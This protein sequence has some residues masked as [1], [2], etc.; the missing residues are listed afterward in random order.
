TTTTADLVVD[1]SGLVGS[2]VDLAVYV[3]VNQNGVVDAADYLVY[4]VVVTDNGTAAPNVPVDENKT[5]GAVRAR[6]RMFTPLN[7]P[8]T[9]GR[10]VVRAT[11]EGNATYAGAA[12]TITAAAEA[13]SVQGQVTASG[14]GSV[15]GALVT[16]YPLNE[17]CAVASPST[18]A[19]ASGNFT[20]QVPASFDACGGRLLLALKPGY[21]TSQYGQ[22]LLTF[23]GTDVYTGQTPTVAAAGVNVSGHLY[24][25]GTTTPIPGAL[26]VAQLEDGPPAMAVAFTDKSGAYTIPLVAG[27]WSVLVGSDEHLA[28]QGAVA[29]DRAVEVNVSG[30]AVSGVDLVAET[31]NATISGTVSDEGTPL[32]AGVGV[33][34]KLDGDCEGTDYST[35]VHTTAGGTF[36][37]GVYVPASCSNQTTIRYHVLPADPV[38]GKVVAQGRV[39]PTAGGSYTAP[40]NYLA[41]THSVSG[42]FVDAKGAALADLCLRAHATVDDVDYV[43]YGK[44][45][46]DGAYTLPAIDGAWSVT[47][48]VSQL[49]AIY[50]S[51]DQTTVERNVTVS[52]A[53]VEGMNFVVGRWLFKPAITG[54]AAM[55]PKAGGQV[56]LQ[57]QGVHSATDVSIDGTTYAGAATIVRVDQ[58][59]AVV[60]L[61]AGLAAGAHQITITDSSTGLP[62]D[63]ACFTSKSPAYAPVCTIGG[64]V[65]DA[66]GAALANA[67]VIVF[68]STGNAPLWGA[69][70]NASGQWSAGMPQNTNYVVMYLPPQGTALAPAKSGVVACATGLTQQLVSAY[71]VGGYVKD[72][73]G[74]GVAGVTV[75][76]KGG[77]PGVA[78][79][80]DEDGYYLLPLRAS[81]WTI[82]YQPPIGGRYLY[83]A[84]QT[85]TASGDTQLPNVA[86]ATGNLVV[87]QV[88][89]M[90]GA[91]RVEQILA[92]QRSDDATVG[93]T[94]SDSCE[95]RFALAVTSGEYSLELIN[96]PNDGASA[97]VEWV[98]ASNTDVAAEFPFPA[99]SAAPLQLDGTTMRI[100]G[101]LAAGLKAGGAFHF[102]VENI[103]AT[104]APQFT[105]S[106]GLGGTVAATGLVVDR[107]RGLVAGTVPGGAASGPATFT[108]GAVSAA[109]VLA[110]V[111]PGVAPSLPYTFAGTVL[112]SGGNPVPGT[113]LILMEQDPGNP[114]C[115]ANPALVSFGVS[116]AS[117][118][119]SLRYTDGNLILMGLPPV[120]ANIPAG[121]ITQ[122]DASG[123]IS[124]MTLQL[125]AGQTYTMRIVQ[126]S[127]ATPV[128]NA[129]VSLDG[130]IFDTRLSA[131]DGTVSFPIWGG[132]E[133]VVLGPAKSRLTAR[134][135]GV[136]GTGSGALGDIALGNAIFVSG[137]TLDSTGAPLGGARA[138]THQAN[139]DTEYGEAFTGLNGI[140]TVP[141]ANGAAFN[142]ELDPNRDDLGSVQGQH[143]AAA[144]DIVFHPSGQFVKAGFIAGHVRA[145]ENGAALANV[146]VS[147]MNSTGPGSSNIGWSRS[148]ADGYYV[149]KVAAGRAFVQTW[150]ESGA[151]AQVW[152][153][154]VFC[155]N[156]AQAV[157]VT[158]GAT[159]TVDM[160]APLNATIGGTARLYRSALSGMTA[161]V[162]GGVLESGCTR[163][164]NSPTGADGVFSISVPAANGYRLE[165]WGNAMDRCYPHNVCPSYV[166]VNAPASGLVI[167]FGDAPGEASSA[168]VP[169]TVGRSSGN[170]VLTFPTLANADSYNVYAGALGTFF[171]P[172]SMSACHLASGSAGFDAPGSG[173]ATYTFVPPAGNAVW[174]LVSGSNIIAEGSLGTEQLG[175]GSTPERDAAFSAWRCGP[176]P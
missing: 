171:N 92:H 44:A 72:A 164:T 98:N 124:G 76:A 174:F 51:L 114:D 17:K 154:G 70:T 82:N 144:H 167:N 26:I 80:T 11:D 36:T 125:L 56:M 58:G 151:R 65:R 111:V 162:S 53:D 134:S 38:F 75:N 68:D 173:A 120:A 152:A 115:N 157:T 87:G 175:D 27:Q 63:P 8:Y 131:A 49:A 6:L 10:Y 22:P 73:N 15:P 40:I 142:I 136:D 14:G 81:S 34:A 52:G 150:D 67:A 116:D 148:C 12:L 45:G 19:D 158:A 4:T 149:M 54:V 79:T 163:C 13:Q 113:V 102:F 126:G 143:D 147:A 84:S 103:P 16:L 128:A 159:T 47:S 127:P 86:L 21:V 37:L 117:G 91:P 35:I 78:A 28:L 107:A 97:R 133:V 2:K 89:G 41:P 140:F 66:G 93:G 129:R 172:S 141:A 9:A 43:A 59:K 176:T 137:R 105:F 96:Q 123:D 108:V 24:F 110:N 100:T 145:S 146:D 160:S 155:S 74:N 161:C 23:R 46:C 119:F 153:P 88:V 71:R 1:V 90:D 166:P 104:G 42:A 118:N 31:P 85:I 62:S 50:R 32:G 101:D 33:T 170:F 55:A 77:G 122:G 64:T 18:F 25:D 20:L 99:A 135:F 156:N 39:E 130:N 57:I 106:N 5:A 3:D 29:N 112:D 61:P 69:L 138:R 83:P 48:N 121:Y 132:Q 60:A 139:G 169:T 7:F 94:V 109:P 165:A 95:G 168:S 30:S